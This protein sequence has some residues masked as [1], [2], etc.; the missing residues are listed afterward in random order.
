MPETCDAI[1][2]GA[3]PAGLGATL[4]LARAGADV[5]LVEAADRVG[6]LCVTRRRDG[7]GYDIGGHIPFVRDHARLAWL[8][9]LVGDDLRWVPR[10]VRSVRDG[11]LRAGR[12]L[13]QPG[14]G[15]GAPDGDPASALGWLSALRGRATVEAEM[16]AYL[17]KIDGVPLE[18]IPADRAR[19]LLEDQAAP[20][21]FH[22]PAGGIGQLMDAMAAAAA[23]AG[24]RILTGTRA[25]EVDAA[26]G[27]MRGAVLRR[28]GEELAV[29]APRA[30]VAMPAG[31]AVRLFR[32][33]P[34]PGEVGPV[35]MRAVCIAYLEAAPAQAFRDAWVQVDDPEVPFARLFAP[36]NWSAGLVPGDRTVFGCE[37]YCRPEPD[38][39]VWGSSD[40]ALVAA[41]ARALTGRLG[42][43]DRSAG[44]RALEVLRLPGAYP[45]PDLRQVDAV[46][47]PAR[48]LA[49]L[50][51]VHHAPGAAVI[52]A[53]EGGE[54][55]AA[56]ALGA[57]AGVA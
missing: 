17:E 24:A 37:C 45:L 47:A 57:A 43:V 54:R 22:F 20:D 52:E 36:G 55:A 42:W 1:V 26:G 27:R 10:P 16:R 2:L 50:E 35:R 34:A 39:P 48:W 13:D 8:R 40:E 38:D 53:I 56:A 3:G 15:D 9:E 49:G 25:R 5:T 51:G 33:G 30:V 21:G 4:A 44:L 14:E 18:R 28:A 41:C 23:A 6:G 32:P 29:R 12:Y 11:R 46:Q 31:A 19:R 7:V